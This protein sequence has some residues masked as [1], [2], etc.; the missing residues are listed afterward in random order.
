[1]FKSFRAFEQ[2]SEAE[3]NKV[4]CFLDVKLL[5]EGSSGSVLQCAGT[6]SLRWIRVSNEPRQTCIYIYIVVCM[7]AWLLYGSCTQVANPL[8]KSLYLPVPKSPGKFICSS[9][10]QVPCC[11]RN[12]AK[13]VLARHSLTSSW[14]GNHG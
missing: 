14:F 11:T 12:A 8:Q 7:C 13:M 5:V 4:I 2:P 9:A 3:I 6:D 1:M 10:S